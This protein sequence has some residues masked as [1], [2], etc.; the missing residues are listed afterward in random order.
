VRAT[1]GGLE[2]WEKRSYLQH[3]PICEEEGCPVQFTAS[4]EEE[5]SEI[6]GWA[7]ASGKRRLLGVVIHQYVV[8]GQILKSSN[9]QNGVRANFD[10]ACRNLATRG[11]FQVL[12]SHFT[13]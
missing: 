1:E 3:T 2:G 6:K 5:V 11:N 4:F 13:S 9:M 10:Q 12:G 8:R 7:T